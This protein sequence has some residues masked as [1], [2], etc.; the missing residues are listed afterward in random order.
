[1]ASVCKDIAL[2]S[3]KGKNRIWLVGRNIKLT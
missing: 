1:M 2:Y 3:E